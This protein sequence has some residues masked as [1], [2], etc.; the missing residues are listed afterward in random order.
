VPAEGGGNL[1][2]DRIEQIIDGNA[3]GAGSAPLPPAP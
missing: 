3:A 2:G 1:D